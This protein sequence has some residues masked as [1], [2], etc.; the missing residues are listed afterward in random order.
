MAVFRQNDL[1]SRIP[2]RLPLVLSQSS[3]QDFTDCR[4]R[5][6]LRYL[7]HTSWPAVQSEPAL[8]NERYM[9]QGTRF[10][11]MVHQRLLGVP[12]ALL[13]A[14]IQSEELQQWWQNFLNL[15][16]MEPRPGLFSEVSLS[17]ALET[18]RLAATYDV[19]IA[20]AD[21]RM[22]IYDWKTSRRRP[23]REWL[24][25]RLQTRVYPYLLA[26]A[27]ASLANGSPV[28]AEAIEMVYWFA[29]FPEQPERFAYSA[30]Q[31]QQDEAYLSGLAAEIERLRA[32]PDSAASFPLTL[33]LE[34]CA[35]CIYRSLCGRG[36]RAADVADLPEGQEDESGDITLDFD[37][38]G[39]E[40][41]L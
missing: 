15:P 16:G 27:G 37:A 20:E 34:R 23:R 5:F 32:A 39:E 21:G 25:E 40:P 31:F 1:P 8:E 11:R 4:R 14:Q 10:H 2:Q 12:P 3:L 35:T 22:T 28:A 26:R 6:E 36:E 19:V 24:T 13:E 29:G 38:L 18:G 9:E 7:L 30:A 41:L 17:A 33:R